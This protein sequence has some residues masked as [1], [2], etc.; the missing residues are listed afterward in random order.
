[1]IIWIPKS[2]DNSYFCEFRKVCTWSNRC[3]TSC[4]VFLFLIV[5]CEKSKWITSITNLQND[6]KIHSNVKWCWLL[7]QLKFCSGFIKI[8]AIN[9][10]NGSIVWTYSDFKFKAP[11]STNKPGRN[12]YQ[13]PYFLNDLDLKLYRTW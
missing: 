11:I 2:F 6:I 8:V 5:L 7:K 1:M 9:S 12:G 10:R 3:S 13:W 4:S